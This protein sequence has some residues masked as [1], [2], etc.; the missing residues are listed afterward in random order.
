MRV[1]VKMFI[2]SI[3][4]Y[5]VCSDLAAV[6]TTTNNV[7]IMLINM[8][9]YLKKICTCISR[10]IL[11]SQALPTMGTKDSVYMLIIFIYSLFLNST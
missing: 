7:Y 11:K 5:L 2:I 8:K 9:I 10:M 3:S 1:D 6:L 4:F